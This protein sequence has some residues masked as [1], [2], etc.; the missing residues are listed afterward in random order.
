MCIEMGQV[1]VNN[2][3]LTPFTEEL[4]VKWW[5]SGLGFG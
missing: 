5:G 2:V 1:I 3:A 4:G